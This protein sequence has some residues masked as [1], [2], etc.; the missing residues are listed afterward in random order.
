MH[1]QHQSNVNDRIRRELFVNDVVES[2]YLI[3]ILIKKKTK[4][5]FFV[6]FHLFTC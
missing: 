4:S 3:H 6:C 5:N 2:I 1:I